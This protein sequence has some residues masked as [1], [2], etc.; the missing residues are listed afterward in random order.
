MLPKRFLPA[1]LL[2][3]GLAVS[4][5]LPMARA[6]TLYWDG[7]STGPDADGGTGTWNTGA[8]NL[9]WDTAAVAGADVP[10]TNGSFAT[11]A[12]TGGAVAVTGTV[13]ATSLTF[14][15]AGYSVTGGTVNLTGTPVISIGA[16]DVTLG[17]AISGNAPISKTGAGTLTLS[18]GNSFGGV[19]TI[20]EGVI[21][22]GSA[23]AFGAG[24]AGSGT[25]ITSGA[26]IDLNGNTLLSEYF[27]VS[28]TGVGGAGAIVNNSPTS[29]AAVRA[30]TLTGPTTVG[31]TKNWEIGSSV[32]FTMAAHTLTKVGTNDVSISSGVMTPGNFDVK[33][34]GLWMR[35]GFTAFLGGTSA[36]VLTIRTGAYLGQSSDNNVA[37][38]WSLVFESG[39]IWKGTSSGGFG[40]VWQ[41]PVTLA[42]STTVDVAGTSQLVASGVISGPGSVTK[43]GFGTWGVYSSNTYAGGTT[44]NA[45]TLLL[46]GRHTPTGAGAVRGPVTLN[47]GTTLSLA[48]ED[49]LGIT[50]GM[51]V[52]PLNVNNAVVESTLPGS[53]R[54][55]VVNLSGSIVRSTEGGSSPV[56]AGYFMMGTGAQMNVLPAGV[57]SLVSGRLALGSGPGPAVFNVSDGTATED[58]RVNAAVTGEDSGRGLTKSGTGLMV[59]DGP[60][61]FTG[62][63]TVEGGTLL[64]GSVGSFPASPVAVNGNGRFGTTAAGKTVASVTAAAGSTL[65]LPATAGSGLGING[66]LDLTSGSVAV[67]PVL[68]AATASGTYDLATAG[69]IT[70]TGMPVLDLSGSYGPTRATGSLAVSGNKLQLTLTGTGGN[71]VWNNA[72]AAGAATGIWDTALENFS[73]GGNSTTFQAFDSVTF[74]D[75]VAPGSA[76]TVSI[77]AV[78]APA[79]LT[80]D[81]SDGAYTFSSTGRLA[82][83]GSLVKTGTSTLTIAGT[84][85]YAM[86][87]GITAAGGILDFS[88]KDIS[89]ERLLVTGG[90]FNNATATL[91]AAEFQSGRAA[92]V[93][94]GSAPWIKTTGGEMEITADNFLTGPGT[95]AGGSLLIGNTAAP[96]TKGSLGSGPVNIAA[97]ASLT[98]SRSDQPVVANPFS[99][100]GTLKLAGSYTGAFGPT[101]TFRFSADNSGFSG[102]LVL[103]GVQFSATAPEIGTGEITIT[104]KN[105]VNLSESVFP[106]AI[107]FVQASGAYTGISLYNA[108]LTGP[109]L[110]SPGS[111]TGFNYSTSNV[112]NMA[113]DGFISGS[114]QE[115]APG[116]HLTFSSS[117]SGAKLIL[118]G[119]STY[120]GSTIISGFGTVEIAGSLGATAV[121]AQTFSNLAGN[122]TIGAGGSLTFGNK[123]TLH[124]KTTGGA[125]TVNGNVDLGPSLSI[126]ID[127][128][129]PHPL[130]A[131]I[132]VLNYAGTLTGGAAQLVMDYP[133]NYRQAV[134]AFNPGQITVDIGSKALI[135][136]GASGSRWEYGAG[137]F[138]NT[139]GTGEP[140]SFCRGDSV[141]FDDTATS[142]S[143][144]GVTGAV[145][146]STVLVDNT[147][148]EYI[149]SA[150]ITG[151]CAFTKRG[152]GV[153]KLLGENTYTGGLFIEGGTVETG[154]IGIR[155]TVVTVSAGGTLTGDAMTS[156]PLTIAGT[157]N[158][159]YLGNPNNSG[160]MTVGPVT[161]TGT[162]ACLLDS[163]SSD[164]ITVTGNLDLTGS[165]LALTKDFSGTNHPASFTILTYTGTLTGGFAT[166]TGMPS[167][168]ELVHD[169]AN[170]KFIILPAD[171]DNWVDRFEGLADRTAGGDPDSD[172]WANLIEFVLGGN[173]GSN[174]GSLI[175]AHE[176]D[177]NNLVFR[178]KRRDSSVTTTTQIVQWGN[179]LAG[180]WNDIPVTE[181][182]SPGVSIQTNGGLSDDVTV[183]LPRQ[184]GKM[185]VRL[186]VTEK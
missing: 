33:E 179:N 101:S 118:S 98:F 77:D 50:P 2:V 141:V 169:A 185:F 83:A 61:I 127:V 94:T 107:R 151:S 121:T 153:L 22:A 164:H 142:T 63:T 67:A 166:V 183:T 80:V 78:L 145:S 120:T 131:P 115:T 68:G 29:L 28:G 140:D 128:A 56:A 109:I 58:L 51:R 76:K 42:G 112:A 155:T 124:V 130:N 172:G 113:R 117:L 5:S 95:V 10:W 36:N 16:N 25:I 74:N 69:S 31:G 70:G 156:G 4:S 64:I 86:T 116:A 178:Y 3:A 143:V 180:S 159:G 165:T 132:P 40:P 108:S 122:G 150:S 27:S 133:N 62:G 126:G 174:D 18:G 15:S 92:A 54:F 177:E 93:L 129:Q 13:S 154:A 32:A 106:N 59:L 96:T 171:F 91:G 53:N 8:A 35:Q 81:N 57:S 175:Q 103:S 60:A 66:T 9:N 168:F 102:P 49:T 46:R 161:L 186:K 41:G 75:S 71:L 138:W 158:P 38:P 89:V 87:G 137:L 1:W 34:G 125:L 135:W 48:L 39:T 144:S 84:D 123:A 157:V 148:K 97:G 184:P 19:L 30:L 21:K 173:P 45:G 20:S 134:F 85:R 24:N 163:S 44:V 167:G 82:G 114:I 73:L 72:A 110:V 119:N 6:A 26:T 99:G 181:N 23:N 149:I 79:L 65:V 43:T 152:T 147:T 47:S 7:T 136:N 37:I 162:Y 100:F 139:T 90:E 14:Q 111:S 160:Y 55:D 170:R 11:F 146:P 105:S 104:G 17:S 176:L 182:N 52:T 88:G 12:G